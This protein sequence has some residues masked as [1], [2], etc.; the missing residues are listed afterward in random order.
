M[1]CKIKKN[2]NH[3]NKVQQFDVLLQYRVSEPFFVAIMQ[4]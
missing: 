2:Y 1:V 4:S 3:E